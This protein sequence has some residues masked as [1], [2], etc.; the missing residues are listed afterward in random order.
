MAIRK[1]APR[2]TEEQRRIRDRVERAR[3]RQP[4]QDP[5]GEHHEACCDI[6]RA[7]GLD[8]EHVLDAWSERAAL[9]QWDGGATQ[10]DA[11]RE[12]VDDVRG[13]FPPKQGVML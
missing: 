4:P 2:E 11:E 8:P 5:T 12:A 7:A 13:M 1:L 9:R 3:R 10:A 6:A